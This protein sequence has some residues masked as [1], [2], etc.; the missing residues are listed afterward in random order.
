MTVIVN[1]QEA[2]T[3]LSRL[4][5]SVDEGEEVVIANRGVPLAKLIKYE[6]PL[7]RDLGFVKGTLPDSFFDPMEADD[8]ELWGL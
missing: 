3:Q 5:K 6:P 2:K 7:K 1:T 4:L 8:L